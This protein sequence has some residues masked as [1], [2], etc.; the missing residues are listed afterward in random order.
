MREYDKS[1]LGG[2]CEWA[3]MAYDAAGI[4]AGVAGTHWLLLPTGRGAQIAYLRQF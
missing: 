4:A 2:R 3:S 1:H